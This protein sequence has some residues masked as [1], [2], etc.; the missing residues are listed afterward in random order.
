MSAHVLTRGYSCACTTATG[1]TLRARVLLPAARQ[2]QP[3]SSSTSGALESKYKPVLLIISHCCS[4]LGKHSLSA[5]RPP[6]CPSGGFAHQWQMLPSPSENISLC[7]YVVTKK[8]DQGM[9]LC[10]LFLE[11]ICMGH[12]LEHCLPP[13]GLLRAVGRGCREAGC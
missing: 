7:V 2:L 13:T 10:C 11:D 3:A 1:S 12:V 8:P 4:V 5:Q 6:C 9:L